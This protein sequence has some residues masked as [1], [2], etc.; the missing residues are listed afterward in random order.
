MMQKDKENMKKRVIF[1]CTG[2]TCRSPMAEGLFRA[3]LHN[4]DMDLCAEVSSAGLAAAIGEPPAKN[5]VAAAKAY[6][7][8]ISAHRARALMQA[9]LTKNTYFVCMTSS[10]EA[11]LVQY[12][13]ADHILTLNIADPFM[14][15]EAVYL[16]CADSIQNRI[17]EIFRFVFGFDSIMQMQETDVSQLVQLEQ[18]CFAHPWSEHAFLEEM[19]NPTACFYVL[20]KDDAV[21]GYIGANDVAGEVYIANIAVDKQQRRCGFAFALLSV[22][23]NVA[24]ARNAAFISLEV[25]ESNAAARALY[26]RC[27]FQEVGKRKEFYRDPAEDALIYTK[28]FTTEGEKE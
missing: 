15:D 3:Y 23:I 11:A 27:G 26:A 18:A 6:G 8:D 4:N 21:V 20:H 17:P 1:V 13:S 25:R 19:N 16:H 9:D 7:A 5:A 28:Y 10:H 12:V 2:N 24:Q 22:L 14:G